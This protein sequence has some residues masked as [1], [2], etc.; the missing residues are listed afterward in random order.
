MKT[1]EL[2]KLFL[3]YFVETG[4]PAGAQL[5]ARA[6]QG[7]LRLADHR[8]HAAVQAILH[9]S[10]R[11]PNRRLTSVQKCFRT[12]D[13]DRVGLTA[14]HCTFFEMLGNFSI[15]DYFKEGAIRFAWEFSIDFLDLDVTASGSRTSRVTMRSSPTTEATAVWESLGVPARAHGGTAAQRQLLGSRGAHR[16]LRALLRALLRQGPPA[17]LRRPRVPAR[18]RL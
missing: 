2:R 18:L 15:G 9:G 8:G 6:V 5:L 3:D 14:R 1:A 16:A 12:S 7:S 4:A 11:A 17:R 13:I 10:G